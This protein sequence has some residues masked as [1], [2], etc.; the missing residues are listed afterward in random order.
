MRQPAQLSDAIHILIYIAFIENPDE[1]TSDV[2]A[3]SVNTNPARVRKIMGQLK[4]AGLLIS[5]RGKSEPKLAKLLNEISI[6]DVYQ[7]VNSTQTL[8]A[9][10]SDVCAQCIVGE[11]IQEI[12]ETKFA[13]I[14]AVA[15]KRMASI[16]LA[17]IMDDF[18]Q[19]SSSRHPNNPE[20]YE[21]MR[22]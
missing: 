20:L 14:Q 12:V 1:L 17:E 21:H 16:T 18:I 6:L 19:L 11:S 9:I 3:A 8:L 4:K 5:T 2:I 15:Q 13:D 22:G 10:D 7:A